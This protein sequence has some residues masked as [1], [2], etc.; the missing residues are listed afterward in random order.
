VA[1]FAEQVACLENQLES[2]NG[3]IV[4]IQGIGAEREESLSQLTT[5]KQLGMY[6][7]L[8]PTLTL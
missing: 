3:E 8:T 4:D 6:P 1:A 7:A 5:L 2:A